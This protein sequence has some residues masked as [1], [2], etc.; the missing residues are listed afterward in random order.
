MC[1]KD[2]YGFVT[3]AKISL[4]VSDE[5]ISVTYANQIIVVILI[6]C[7]SGQITN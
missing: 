2:I 4:Q 3:A 7:L 5:E 6:N 1:V